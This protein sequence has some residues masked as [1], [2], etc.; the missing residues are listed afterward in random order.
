MA[1]KLIKNG[2][3]YNILS[4]LYKLQLVKNIL[5]ICTRKQLKILLQ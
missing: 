3:L 4:N 5:Q 1:I 2:N